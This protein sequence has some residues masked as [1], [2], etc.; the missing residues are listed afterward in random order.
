MDLQTAVTQAYETKWS[1]INTFTVQITTTPA[2]ESFI[3]QV[4]SKISLLNESINLNIISITTPD[5]TNDPIEVFTANKWFVHNGKDQLYRFSMTFRD[6][7]QMSLY[8]LFYKIYNFSNSNYFDD[9]KMTIKVMKD[10]DWGSEGR[11][12]F[13]TFNDVFIEG[14]SN[15]T[16]SNTTENQIAEFSVNFKCTGTSLTE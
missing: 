10:A 8:R 1:M 4:D 9:A 3:N 13:M 7:D 15:V 11:T 2:M 6:Q 16:F 5:F 14:I 12:M